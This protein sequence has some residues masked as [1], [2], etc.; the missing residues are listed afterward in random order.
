PERVGDPPPFYASGWTNTRTNDT[1][2]TIMASPLGYAYATLN[3]DAFA[4]NHGYEAMCA[5]FN[6][7]QA[8][9]EYIAAR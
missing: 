9:T 2:F 7:Y 6:Y 5:L 1:S 3:A 4:S 8:A